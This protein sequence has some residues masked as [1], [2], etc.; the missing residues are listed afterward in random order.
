MLER[1]VDA[2]RRVVIERIRPEI[3]CGRFAN[4]RVVGES[5]V[6]EADVFADGHDQ[7]VCRVLFWH[8]TEKEP[9][10][11]PMELLVNDRWRGEVRVLE[12]GRYRYT[13][14]GWAAFLIKYDAPS[15]ERR[16]FPAAARKHSV[17]C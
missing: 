8:G 10:S 1:H 13:V 14:E 16:R 9:Q 12:I 2:R 11:S 6:V 3:N 17:K 15:S 5:V 7:L 4:K